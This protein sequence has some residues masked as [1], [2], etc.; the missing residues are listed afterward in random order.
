MFRWLSYAVEALRAGAWPRVRREHLLKEPECVACGR[1]KDLEVHH[2]VPY[3]KDHSLELDPA[4]LVTLCADPCHFVHG[5]L[6]SWTRFNPEVRED[7][8]R[9]RAKLEQAKHG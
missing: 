7:C 3:S 8:A 2:I 5:H 9:Y 4:N 6:M 1:A